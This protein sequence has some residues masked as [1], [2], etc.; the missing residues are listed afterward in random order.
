MAY[1]GGNIQNNSDTNPRELVAEA[2]TLAD[3]DVNFA[4]FDNDLN[5][6]VDGVYV[7]YAG[8]GEEA[9]ASADAIWR[10]LGQFRQH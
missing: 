4:D 3:A 9:G 8:Y 2:V 7:I 1:Y 5:G 10:M 6:S